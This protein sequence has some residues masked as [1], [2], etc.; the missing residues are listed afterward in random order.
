MLA[1]ADHEKMRAAA[2]AEYNMIEVDALP[3]DSFAS[4]IPKRPEFLPGYLAPVT[5][6][7]SGDSADRL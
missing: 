2:L 5:D 3:K 7:E 6:V 1:A 4:K